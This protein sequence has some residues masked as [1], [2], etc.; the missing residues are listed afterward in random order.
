MPLRSLALPAAAALLLSACATTREESA[1]SPYSGPPISLATLTTVTQILS[2]DDYE[3]RA[4]TTKGEEKTIAYIAQ[5][6]Q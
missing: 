2:S 1:S 6:F 4:P 5:R 3:G